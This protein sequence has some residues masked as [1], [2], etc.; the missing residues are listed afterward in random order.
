MSTTT[1]PNDTPDEIT[2]ACSTCLELLQSVD[3]LRVIG[4]AIKQSNCFNEECITSIF[5]KIWKEEDLS[6]KEKVDI[7]SFLENVITPIL[8]KLSDSPVSTKTQNP[9]EL[10]N[11]AEFLEWIFAK[12]G[13]E[14]T[15]SGILEE[16]WVDVSERTT[17]IIELSLEAQEAQKRLNTWIKNNTEYATKH[18]IK[19]NVKITNE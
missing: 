7:T 19:E 11:F 4:V 5:K 9:T 16:A 14:T 18:N 10:K 3:F 2:S 17:N 1:P 8:I 12:D 6:E 13:F 15:K